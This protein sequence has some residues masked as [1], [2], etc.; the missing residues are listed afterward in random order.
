MLPIFD[1]PL[2]F[3][4]LLAGFLTSL[5]RGLTPHCPARTAR[6]SNS[7]SLPGAHRLP[8]TPAT[9]PSVTR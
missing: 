4:R 8:T 2:A 5:D 7:R 9:S 6:R 3:F 1:S